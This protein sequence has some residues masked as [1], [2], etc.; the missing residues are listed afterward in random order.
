MAAELAGRGI[1]T[2]LGYHYIY[3]HYK[4][5]PLDNDLLYSQHRR[6]STILGSLCSLIFDYC[7]EGRILT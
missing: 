4:P 3:N 6:T 7:N 5:D 2:I 1:I